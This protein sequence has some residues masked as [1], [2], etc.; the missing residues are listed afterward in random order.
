MTKAPAPDQGCPDRLL[1]WL[2]GKL[3]GF[4]YFRH[5]VDITLG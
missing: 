3:D 5:G 4:A 1:S 2:K